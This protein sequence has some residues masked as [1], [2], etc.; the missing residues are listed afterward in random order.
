MFESLKKTPRFGVQSPFLQQVRGR[1]GKLFLRLVLVLVPLFLLRSCL[2]TYVPP[3][4]IGVRQISYGPS[5]GLQ[6]K[7][8]GSGYRREIAS[9]EAIHTFPRD[10]QAVEFTGHPAER[11][12]STLQ[13]PAIKVPTV[14]GYPVDV[15]VTVLYRL[16]DPYKIASQ[17]GFSRAYEEAIV[18]R[19]T[20]PLVK[21]F[22]GELRAEQFYHEQR[23]H[24][25]LALKRALAQRFA[26]NGL[27]LNDVLI[28]QY[29]YPETFQTLTEQKK[30]QDQ[31]VLANREFTK[32][33]EVQTRL[34]QMKA[35]GQNLI[36]VRTSEF[37]AQ[38][39]EIRAKK[40]LYERQK[41]A[42]ADLLVKSAE[43]EG[44]ELINRALEGA[45]SAKL[46]RLRRG[47]ALLNA[48]KGPI[49]IS[50]DPTDLGRI[51]ND[52]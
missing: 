25:V 34:N 38:I 15:D 19:F 52:H 5:K 27:F 17:F 3:G 21:Q 11:G 48:I 45:G 43:A 18:V 35:E 44:T 23:L 49:Y 13:R 22:L 29:D 31:S 41:R 39:T 28:R 37:N 7:P 30:I 40:E 32:Q 50:E 33:A 46:L 10:I 36:N 12:A 47:L 51:V 26:A 20:D 1:F 8:V 14:D 16:A 6:K 2:I 42:E 4:E 9:Y 24:Q